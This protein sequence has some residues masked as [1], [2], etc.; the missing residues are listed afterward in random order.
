F[1]QEVKDLFTQNKDMLKE[2]L[3]ESVQE[4]LEAQMSDLL[5][6][7]SYERT[8][9]RRGY[10]AGYYRRHLNTRVGMIELRVPQ[11]RDGQFSTDVFERYQRSEKALVSSMMEMYVQGV[12]TRKVARITEELCG[13]GFSAATVS[14][15][16]SALDVK[17]EKFARRRLEEEY[18]YLILDA[19]YEKV[20]IDGTVQSQAVLIALG[21]GW[22]G[23]REVLAVEL[24][25]RESA[26]IWK[27]FLDG[28]AVRGLHG[29]EFVVSDDHCGIRKAV[30]DVLP[31]AAWQRCYVHFLRNALD[32]LPRKADP[33]C[34]VEL[35]WLY[36]RR[37]AAEARRDLAAWLAK[38]QPKY[39]KLCDWVEENIEETF[40]FYRLPAAH[41]KHLKSTNMLE[42]LNQELKRRTHI[43]RIFPNEASC[44]RLVRALAE[45]IHEEWLE[46]VRYLDMDVLKEHRKLLLQ[47]GMEPVSETV[48]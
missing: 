17:L 15:L 47:K 20:R 16:T 32:H 9:G 35:R 39:P 28:L 29:V 22:D 7:E 45:E 11:D 33:D 4:I 14:S 37:N 21:V 10:R 25:D 2:L 19:R 48:A 6:A 44:L 36:D 13:V 26:S 5:N 43:V 23:R 40:T 46:A 41:H 38:W 3:Q 30:R 31:G 27:D 34:L 12:S 1:P 18:P 24:A 42:R 8:E